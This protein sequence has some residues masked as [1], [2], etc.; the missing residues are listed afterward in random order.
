MKTKKYKLMIFLPVF[1]LMGFLYCKGD[2]PES[3]QKAAKPVIVT[4][5]KKSSIK[6]SYIFTG[7]IQPV[8]KVNVVPDIAGK[9]VKI[10]VEEG[11]YVKKGQLLAKLDT[12]PKELQLNQAKA[13]YE[14]AEASF[15]DAKRNW[16]RNKELYE[17]ET[18]SPQQY[19]KAKLAFESAK[20]QLE[21]AK[22]NYELSEYQLEVSFMKAPFS[23]YITGKNIDE[24][25]PVN[26]M[27]PG[28]LGVVTLMDISKVKIRIGLSEVLFP[29]IKKGLPVIVTVDPYPEET[30]EGKISTVNPV[31]DPRSRTFD[32]EIEIP[33]PDNKLRSGMFAR[34]EIIVDKKENT[35]VLPMET[36]IDSDAGSYV[37]VVE[38]NTAKKKFIKKGIEEK[39][40]IEIISGINENDLVVST[41]QEML[42]DGD[43]V[44][45]RK[46]D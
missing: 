23:G 35:I 5:A 43:S 42:N 44:I 20:A 9:V 39:D 7:N 30:F 12:K 28:G 41:G 17:K 10:Y 1:L 34:V 33:N 19:E 2:M 3:E 32:C 8:K 25:E 4:K 40:R 27:T 45:I 13:A 21:Q 6:V 31:A 46:G 22:A 36:I 15:N 16:E 14:V 11:D 26:P 24:N 37:Y 29:K 38:N 18:L